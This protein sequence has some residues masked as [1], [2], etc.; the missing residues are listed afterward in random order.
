MELESLE[1][2]SEIAP[3]LAWLNV[4]AAVLFPDQD[5]ATGFALRGFPIRRGKPRLNF[6]TRRLTLSLVRF[7]ERSQARLMPLLCRQARLD[8]RYDFVNR[9]RCWL[10][11]CWRRFTGYFQLQHDRWRIRRRCGIVRGLFAL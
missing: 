6:L 10:F 8:R 4:P 11:P 1:A 3:P 9:L 7:K 5:F 2:N